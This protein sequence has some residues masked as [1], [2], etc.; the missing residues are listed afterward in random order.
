MLAPGSV[1][2]QVL[3]E[4]LSSDQHFKQKQELGRWGLLSLKHDYPSLRIPLD[5]ALPLFEKQA[6]HNY[7]G[8]QL[9]NAIT[10]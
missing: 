1:G 9:Y 8:P 7:I 5:V 3:S 6:G 10:T 2:H 4:D